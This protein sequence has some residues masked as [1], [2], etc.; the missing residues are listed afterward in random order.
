MDNKSDVCYYV[1]DI[2]DLPWKGHIVCHVPME[3]SC[4]E[5]GKP[6]VVQGQ[7]YTHW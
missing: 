6:V 5:T 3:I 7:R 4:K 2:H 1:C